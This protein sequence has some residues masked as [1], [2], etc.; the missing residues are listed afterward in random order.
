[1]TEKKSF[2]Y[3]NS[4][5]VFTE[6]GGCCLILWG[7][8]I[9]IGSLLTFSANAKWANAPL[10]LIFVG[11][12]IFIAITTLSFLIFAM[13]DNEFY[14]PNCGKRRYAIIRDHKCKISD[15]H[16]IEYDRFVEKEISEI[17]STALKSYVKND[18]EMNIFINNIK[19]LISFEEM[20]NFKFCMIQMG[21]ILEFLLRNYCEAKG[22]KP[23]HK[24]FINY[25][26]SAIINNIFGQKKRWELIQQYL[27]DFRNYIHIQKEIKSDIV[28]KHWY[29]TIKPNFKALYNEFKQNPI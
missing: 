26:E 11:Y 8:V 4:S 2:R 15:K 1:M 19:A 16:L 22:I 18:F 6:D 13:W 3:R 21:S 7:I 14:C 28:D 25:V 27:R 17:K 20:G 12:F 10:D 24:K 23:K 5:F 29:N 9:G